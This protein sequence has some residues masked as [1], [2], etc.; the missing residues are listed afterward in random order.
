MRPITACGCTPPDC[1]AAFIEFNHSEGSDDILGVYPPAGPDWQKSIRKGRDAGLD[2]C[3][4]AEPGSA[5]IGM[6]E[7]WG[8][9]LGLAVSKGAGGEPG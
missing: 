2:G 8:R 3:R 7:H 4:D 9:I 1:R 5:G 6:A